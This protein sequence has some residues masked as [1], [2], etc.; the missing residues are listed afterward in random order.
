MKKRYILAF[1]LAAVA[2]TLLH[3]LYDWLPVPLVGLFA[4][5]NES[6]WEHLKLLFWNVLAAGFVLCRK[7]PDAQRAWS[8]FL[9]ALLL[10]PLGLTGLY[11]LLAAGFGV[12]VATIVQFIAEPIVGLFTPDEAAIVAGEQY[13]R[14]YIFDCIFAGL[15]FSFSGY[16]CACGKSGLSFLHNITA[17][18]LVRVPGVWLMSRMYPQ[19]LLPMGLATAAGSALS[20]VICVIAYTVLRKKEARAALGG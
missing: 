11:Y 5:V 10:M 7:K 19:T 13:L 1:F 18:V 12:V 15:H 8:G 14:G 4:P 16:F 9:A 2:G 6:V 3:F 20:V 17:I